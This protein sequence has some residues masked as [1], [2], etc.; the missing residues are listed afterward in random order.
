MQLAGTLFG[1]CVVQV[2]PQ[3]EKV[4]NLPPGALTKEV[5]LTED[6]LKL[7]IE[8]QAPA[9]LLAVDIATA[10]A[11]PGEESKGA[12]GSGGGGASRASKLE[13]VKQN[14]RSLLATIEEM[15][16]EELKEAR[17]REQARLAGLLDEIMPPQLSLQSSTSSDCKG[18]GFFANS[19]QYRGS[20][21]EEDYD[22]SS[23]Y[24]E[25]DCDEEENEEEEECAAA[26]VLQ[27]R[28]ASAD[29][30]GAQ[31]SKGDADAAADEEV[32]GQESAAGTQDPAAAQ[33]QDLDSG[34]GDG[35]GGGGGGGG[36]VTGSEASAIDLVSLP[37]QL[38]A[39]MGRLDQDGALR[40]TRITL[41]GAWTK[42]TFPGLLSAAKTEVLAEEGQRKE[43]D[44]VHADQR[45]RERE[46]ERDRRQKLRVILATLHAVASS[47]FTRTRLP[48]PPP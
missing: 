7:F 19:L 41:Q 18:G 2:K 47:V 16:E 32:G 44:Q 34:D 3:L 42:K 45:E 43:R 28:A 6:L 30:G 24:D 33:Q 23:D 36:G 15:K 10:A 8:Y 13:A 39:S 29:G 38:N 40:P 4:L 21:Q 20:F 11:A 48:Q 25:D 17:E 46:R 5:E 22:D 27:A 37:K 35:D 12:G 9:D 26:P 31:E 1:V 14:V